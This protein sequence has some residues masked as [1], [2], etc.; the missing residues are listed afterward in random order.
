MYWPIA[1]ARSH[2]PLQVRAYQLAL[3]RHVETQSGIFPAEPAFYERFNPFY[4]SHVRNLDCLGL[5]GSWNEPAIVD[6]YSL[7]NRLMYFID[8]EPDRSIPD[9]P[10]RCYL[11]HFAGK[12]LLFVSPFAPLLRQR[13]NR[14]TFEAVWAKTGKRWFH[15][16]GAEALQMPYGWSK[17]VQQRHSDSIALFEDLA[18]RM[19]RIEFDVALISAGG[20]GIPLASHAKSLGKIGI[21][22][23]GHLQVLFGI[24]G[25]RWRARED[26]Q[27]DYITEAWIDP[28]ADYL[29]T[30]D[31]LVDDGAYW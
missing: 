26:W 15:P 10:L 23:G 3:R 21:S 24:L 29:P 5:F 18:A 7:E 4:V 30:E 20:L 31:I 14:R 19:A 9:D 12:R 27:R 13:A 17:S 8:Q 22:L 2:G 1:R 11:Q 16:A 25:D 28:P 6:H